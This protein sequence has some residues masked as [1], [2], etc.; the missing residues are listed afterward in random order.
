MSEVQVETLLGE[1]PPC[2][3]PVAHI[4][5]RGPGDRAPKKGDKALCGA[6]LMGVDL[7]GAAVDAKTCAECVEIARKRIGL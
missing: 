6:E 3:P 2:W 5:D 4:F 7:Q 1:A